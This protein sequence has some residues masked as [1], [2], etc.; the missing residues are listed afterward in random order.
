MNDQIL[1]IPN[2]SATVKDILWENWP[3]DK[4]VFVA[5]DEDK[6][7]TYSYSRETVNGKYKKSWNKMMV[8][9]VQYI[10]TIPHAN[11][12]KKKMGHYIL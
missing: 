9:P 10:T 5:Y 6:I 11:I 2:F 8:H 1:E 12:W 3:F 4:G 7:Y